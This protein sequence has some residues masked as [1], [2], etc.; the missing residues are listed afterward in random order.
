M[1]LSALSPTDQPPLNVPT[2]CCKSTG[3]LIQ[4]AVLHN[5][6][7]RAGA[8]KVSN[9]AGAVAGNDSGPTSDGHNKKQLDC[10]TDSRKFGLR[11]VRAVLNPPTGRADFA[12]SA[13]FD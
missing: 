9:N 3:Q 2:C 8:S 1:R 7:K 12:P 13:S 5:V 6:A 10:V 4:N 11:C